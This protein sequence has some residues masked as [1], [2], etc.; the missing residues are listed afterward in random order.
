MRVC[1]VQD[2]HIDIFISYA[3]RDQ[4]VCIST[5]SYVL[6]SVGFNRFFNGLNPKP[7]RIESTKNRRLAI[8]NRCDENRI[9]NGLNWI[10]SR[11]NRFNVH[12]EKTTKEIDSL[13][14]EIENKSK[15]ESHFNIHETD[16]NC[17]KNESRKCRAWK[18]ISSD[19]FIDN[20][21][22]FVASSS[23]NC[24]T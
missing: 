14:D 23:F 11:R 20:W 21:R 4:F 7:N 3:S 17:K 13:H 1:C 10:I 12:D 8:R 6:F 15:L 22:D 9:E 2:M 19:K 24:R 18:N 5:S 16:I